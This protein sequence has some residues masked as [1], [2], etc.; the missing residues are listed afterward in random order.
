MG[1][2]WL[3][4]QFCI[5]GIAGILAAEEEVRGPWQGDLSDRK[6]TSLCWDGSMVNISLSEVCP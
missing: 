5:A 3:G 2:R 1:E 4:G 6:V